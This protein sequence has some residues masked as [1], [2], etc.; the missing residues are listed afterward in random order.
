MNPVQFNCNDCETAFLSNH[1]ATY[2]DELIC[3]FKLG[4]MIVPTKFFDEKVFEFV[5]GNIGG[6]Y[7]A[8]IGKNGVA[9]FARFSIQ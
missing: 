4:I 6:Y 1:S 7:F 2:I 3:N 5:T 9:N 8:E